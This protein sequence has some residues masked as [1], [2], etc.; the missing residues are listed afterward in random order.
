MKTEKINASMGISDLLPY[1][2]CRS[3]YHFINTMFVVVYKPQIYMPE[4][5]I[6]TT[7]IP[8]NQFLK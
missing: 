8:I 7:K 6:I 1:K 2:T 3:Y 4:E 5:A